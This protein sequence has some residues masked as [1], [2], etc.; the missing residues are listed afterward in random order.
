[1]LQSLGSQRVD[2][3]L[4]TEQ[5]RQKQ[6]RVKILPLLKK[7]ETLTYVNLDKGFPG[8]SDGK[9]SACNVGD[10]GSIPDKHEII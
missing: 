3:D 7:I 5:Q 2:H 1:M 10:L 9:A 6:R 4:G 8:G